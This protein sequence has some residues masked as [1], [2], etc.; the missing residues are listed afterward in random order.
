MELLLRKY[1]QTCIVHML[2]GQQFLFREKQMKHLLG[3]ERMKTLQDVAN[4]P[5]F[6][7]CQNIIAGISIIANFSV[8]FQG[9]FP[10][11]V[12]VPP[13]KR[14]T[15]CFVIFLFVASLS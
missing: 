10:T 15:F 14:P 1:A 5:Y 6:N 3:F 2:V 8:T 7:V 4:K 12:V 11:W 9:S 13:P